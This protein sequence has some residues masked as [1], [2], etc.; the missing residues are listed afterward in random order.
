MDMELMLDPL[1]KRHIIMRL[2][3]VFLAVGLGGCGVWGFNLQP[4]HQSTRAD[5]ICHPYGD[6]SYGHWVPV[7][8]GI[9]DPADAMTSRVFCMQ[10]IDRSHEN[11]WW[12][13]SVTRGVNIGECMEQRG[14]RLQ[15]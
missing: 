10:E 13:D 11:A 1:Y 7:A 5:Y 6:C 15:Q 4:D 12:K 8:P 2:L 14:F 9:T 3:V